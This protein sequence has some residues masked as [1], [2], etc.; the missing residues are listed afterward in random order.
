[1]GKVMPHVAY[2]THLEGMDERSGN[3]IQGFDFGIDR[4]RASYAEFP[5]G[6]AEIV[7]NYR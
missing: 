4:S 3:A 2:G 1:M 6:Y 7:P 5:G